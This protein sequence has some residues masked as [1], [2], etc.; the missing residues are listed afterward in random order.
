MLKGLYFRILKYTKEKINKMNRRTTFYII[1]ILVV[2][3]L[4]LWLL[5]A[6]SSPLAD[7]SVDIS[8]DTLKHQLGRYR[9]KDMILVEHTGL[10]SGNLKTKGDENF[11]FISSIPLEEISEI[12]ELAKKRDVNLELRETT[13]NEDKEGWKTILI[14]IN[15]VI[16]GLAFSV[17]F[18]LKKA[19]PPVG[20]NL[21]KEKSSVVNEYLLP[22][23]K[24]KDV[25]GCDEA[26]EQLG[27]LIKFLKDPEKFKKLGARMP[28]GYLLVGPPGTGKT[29][30]ARAI[31]GEAEVP[32]FSEKGTEFVEIFVGTGTKRVKEIFKK[33]R[34]NAPC[35]IFIDELD[36][37]GRRR[38]SRSSSTGNH[39]YENTMLQLCAEID[40]FEGS[41]GI[42]LIAATNRPDAL[43][44]ALVRS[45]RFD[46]QV[47]VDIPDL[48]GREKILSIHV[49]KLNI[50]PDLNLKTLINNL[51]KKSFGLVG[52][53]LEDLTNKAAIEAE[54]RIDKLEE[55]D[56]EKDFFVE[57]VDFQKPMD[58]ILMG[59]SESKK[60][61]VDP[62][63]KEL[64]AYHE[65]GHAVVA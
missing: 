9:I 47:L 53:D 3:L 33:G 34:E 36:A 60:K 2:Q 21:D 15:L 17:L 23:T 59:G 48:E 56:S 28:K 31:A 8:F 12:K 45:G 5:F 16:P 55:T 13:P 7:N 25:G 6:N 63:E 19:Y 10:V 62:K 58:D 61:I 14:I 44:P 39:E 37:V 50:S 1:P 49:K 43:D 20:L 38:E 27:V 30:L 64:I 57:E 52:S 46:T 40:G 35:V 29:L 22:E 11:T 18:I 32:F 41:R 54:K 24:F 26:I 51:A 65:A 42:V 4:F